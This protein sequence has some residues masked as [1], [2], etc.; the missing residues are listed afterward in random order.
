[1]KQTVGWNQG[2]GSL[3]TNR[4]TVLIFSWTVTMSFES[5][6]AKN[7]DYANIL[8]TIIALSVC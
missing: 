5:N 7:L 1:M 8:G 4:S 3:A 6:F 2:H